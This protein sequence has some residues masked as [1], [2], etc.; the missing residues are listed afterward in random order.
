M[1]VFILKVLGCLVLLIIVA[2][3]S[4]LISDLLTPRIFF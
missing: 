1:V 3:L 2:I 4:I